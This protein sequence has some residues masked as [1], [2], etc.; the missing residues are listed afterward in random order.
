VRVLLKSE[1]VI[2]LTLEVVF[3]VGRLLEGDVVVDEGV[4]VKSE[5]L[6]VLGDGAGVLQLLDHDDDTPPG[7]LGD[8]EDGI[9]VTVRVLELV[10]DGRGMAQLS[11]H[12]EEGVP[13][14]DNSDDDDEAEGD[15]PSVVVVLGVKSEVVEPDD[16]TEP[17]HDSEVPPEEL[18]DEAPE[19]DEVGDGVRVGLKPDVTGTVAGM[20]ELYDQA[21]LVEDDNSEVLS[22]ELDGSE[23]DVL[24]MGVTTEVDDKFG[25][26]VD[27]HALLLADDSEIS[28]ELEPIDVDSLGVGVIGVEDSLGEGMDVQLLLE[29]VSPEVEDDTLA[30]GV[31]IGMEEDTETD[32]PGVFVTT[33]VTVTVYTVVEV[34]FTPGGQLYPDVF[35]G[36]V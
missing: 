14:E 24:G 3:V 19:V 22:V 28:T 34:E 4:E 30:V 8:D 7:E 9:G 29:V 27:I 16:D 31:R 12:D 18:D 20:L 10:D 32:T 1:K 26:G 21:L 23:D 25:E 15:G 11:D 35:G 2:S 33:E 13:E 6:E 5:V 36:P 17:L